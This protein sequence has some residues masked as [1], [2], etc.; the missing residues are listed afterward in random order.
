MSPRDT[1]AFRIEPMLLSRLKRLAELENESAGVVIRR[2]VI[3]ELDRM[4]MTRLAREIET[5]ERQERSA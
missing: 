3:A 4:A 2:A 1:F 5:L